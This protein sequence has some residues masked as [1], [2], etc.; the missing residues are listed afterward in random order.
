MTAES[1]SAAGMVVADQRPVLE[2]RHVSKHY[3]AV[4]ALHDVSLEL[5]RGEILGLVGD[6]GAGKSTLVNTIAGAL[7]PDSGE[8]LLDGVAH[9]FE[10]PAQARAAG[11]ETVFQYLSIIPTLDIAENVFLNRE[12]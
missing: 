5:R 7:R 11:V 4:R 9:A 1:A 12:L 8:I 3:G 2:V 10:T 6:N